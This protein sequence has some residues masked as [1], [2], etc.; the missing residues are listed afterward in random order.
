MII[1]RNDLFSR[2]APLPRGLLEAH[3]RAERKDKQP[4]LRSSYPNMGLKDSLL[5]NF[6][7]QKVKVALELPRSVY[8]LSPQV[9]HDKLH[10]PI[11]TSLFLSSVTGMP[12][13]TD[14]ETGD[15]IIGE[16]KIF[17]T[18]FLDDIF[19]IALLL[20]FQFVPEDNKGVESARL[21]LER[22]IIARPLWDSIIPPPLVA[23]FFERLPW[24]DCPIS[25]GSLCLYY[26]DQVNSG[27]LLI[28]GIDMTMK[29]LSEEEGVFKVSISQRRSCGPVSAYRFQSMIAGG[30]D[31]SDR[32]EANIN[33]PTLILLENPTLSVSQKIF[34]QPLSGRSHTQH[35]TQTARAFGQSIEGGL[36]E[37]PDQIK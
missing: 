8:E 35:L 31:V 14:H 24:P 29:T 21:E 13:F 12:Y 6:R 25:I 20:E 16:L 26:G 30:I 2:T 11:V 7:Y 23:I 15:P 32:F 17:R 4:P 33:G 27:Q 28:D 22:H 1:R 36:I 3:K 37:S 10:P 18:P 9:E 5:L 34:I 19:G